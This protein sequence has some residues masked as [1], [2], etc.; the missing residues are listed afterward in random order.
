QIRQKVN[1]LSRSDP[2]NDVVVIYYEGGEIVYEEEQL[3]LTTKEA[4]A[5]RDLNPEIV[6]FSVVGSELLSQFFASMGGAHLMFL[7]VVR[8]Q[9]GLVREAVLPNDRR[10]ALLRFAWLRDAE[11][12]DD[13][14]LIVAVRDVLSEDDDLI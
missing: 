4:T 5:L 8:G 1:G 3:F 6:K 11:S 2:M 7:D 14:S 13:A 9:E 12:P 10:T